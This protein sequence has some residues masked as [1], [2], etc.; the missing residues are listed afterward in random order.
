MILPLIFVL[1]NQLVRFGGLA[2]R[3]GSI[4]LWLAPTSLYLF[5]TP[6][7]VLHVAKRRAADLL[8]AKE[9]LVDIE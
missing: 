7:E 2:E 9:E 3:H 5:Q 1:R 4:G 8:L 6:F